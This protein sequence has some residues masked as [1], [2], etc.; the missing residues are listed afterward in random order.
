MGSGCERMTSEASMSI[1]VAWQPIKDRIDAARGE[2]ASLQDKLSTAAP[3]EKPEI[4]RQIKAL[5]EQIAA[6]QTQLDACIAPRL[7]SSR[8]RQ[9]SSASRN[10]PPLARMHRVHSITD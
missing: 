3:A 8:L 10:L 9:S 6:R 4:I 7:Q 1:S 2:R 5:N